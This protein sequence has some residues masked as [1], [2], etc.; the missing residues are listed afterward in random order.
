VIPI[1]RGS[2]WGGDVTLT[3]PAKRFDLHL[4]A[5]LLSSYRTAGAVTYRTG[6]ERARLAVGLAYRLPRDMVMRVALWAGAGRPTTLLQNGMQLESSGVSG[7][8]ELAGSPESVAGP[9]NDGLLANYGRAD[10]GFLKDWGVSRGGAPRITT[11]VTVGNLFN[12]HNVLATVAAPTGT[13]PVFLPSR[14]LMLR[15]RWSL[16]R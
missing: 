15:V 11:A 2:I 7:T 16:A 9:P 10:L 8:G 13:R 4:Q 5:G 12:R 3:Y 6:D 14:T 1:G